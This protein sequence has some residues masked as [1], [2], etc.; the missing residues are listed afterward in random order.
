M[1]EHSDQNLSE[2]TSPN[3]AKPRGRN[4]S[5]WKRARRTL[6]TNSLTFLQP[7]GRPTPASK[8]AD[9]SGSGPNKTTPGKRREQVRHAQR[10]HRQRTQNYI[11]TLEEEVVRL[12]GSEGNLRTETKKLL[13]RVDVLRTA[14]VL[15]DV[16]LP[17]GFEGS[18]QLAD[19][20]SLDSDLSASIS[21]RTDTSNHQRLHIDWPTQS[22]QQPAP[23]LIPQPTSDNIAS[24][25]SD[26]EGWN[27]E[28]KP[29][30]AP[31]QDFDTTF[32]NP[33]PEMASWSLDTPEVAIDFVLALEHCCMGHIPHPA[34]PPSDEPNNHALLMSTALVARGPGPPQLNQSWSADGSMI[35]GL[36]NLAS[37]INLQ[38]E[39]TP[40][41]A[42][43][44]LRQYPGFSRLN[45]WAFENIKARLSAA[46]ECR[47]FGA[48][49][50]E[51]IFL[52]TLGNVLGPPDA[53]TVQHK[54]TV[55]GY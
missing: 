5:L 24:G 43:H 40:V 13:N 48:V 34:A 31:P 54:L 42:W 20:R 27:L 4:D 29:L 8:E 23:S 12:R 39:M 28:G 51:E 26:Y 7:Q 45:K 52:F 2:S 50:D 21:F 17:A 15:N 18:P 38:G 16:P 1:S 6:G 19:P 14:L 10:T 44:R 46:V 25:H 22:N 37:A 41:E 55:Q 9:G 47:E 53:Y 49:I 30:P 35:R 32:E 36:L 33:L 3:P 11:K